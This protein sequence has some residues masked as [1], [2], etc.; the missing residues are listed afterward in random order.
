MYSSGSALEEWLSTSPMLRGTLGAERGAMDTVSCPT[1]GRQNDIGDRLCVHCGKP[2][3]APVATPAGASTGASSP[4][5]PQAPPP[6][7]APLL[8]QQQLQPLY[9]VP[10][11]NGL[12]TAA[13]VLGILC[14]V[15]AWLPPLGFILAILAIVFG[16]VGLGRANAGAG[17]KGQA[18]AGLVLGVIGIVIPLLLLVAAVGI[19]RPPLG[20]IHQIPISVSP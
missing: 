11:A 16:A 18:V 4:P 13:M 7:A 10:P 15:L 20:Q 12:A 6:P 17:N 1:C 3:D 9:M 8:A 5:T 19:C 14:I 2:M